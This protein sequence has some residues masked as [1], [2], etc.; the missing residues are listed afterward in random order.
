MTRNLLATIIAMMLSI[1]AITAMAADNAESSEKTP[2]PATENE[3]AE[4]AKAL[5]DEGTASY[6]AGNYSDAAN[7]FRKANKLNP[8]WRI[9]FNI[10]QCEALAKRH[11]LALQAFEAYLSKGGDDITLTRQAEVRSEIKR[12][13][14]MTGAIEIN[15]PD[16]AKIIVDGVERGVSPLAGHIPVAAGV[17]HLVR[18]EGSSEAPPQSRKVIVVGGKTVALDFRKE[19]K[20][21]EPAAPPAPANVASAPLPVES[22]THISASYPKKTGLYRLALSSLVASGTVFLAAGITGLVARQ[23][24]DQ[25]DERCPD[26]TC[27]N[28]SDYER[29]PDVD[30][31]TLTTDILLAGG[32]ALALTGI[33][34]MAVNRGRTADENAN[35]SFRPLV[36]GVQLEGKF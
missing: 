32:G 11:G 7:S 30:N 3:D 34:L 6:E 1:W 15:A 4:V 14:E 20:S 18:I 23:K 5:F 19:E 28:E 2:P 27:S 16:G 26:K 31:L 13:R 21:A 33:I 35:V 9:Y 22:P 36:G 10:G 24:Y 29:I 25:L 12:L 17:T 8:N